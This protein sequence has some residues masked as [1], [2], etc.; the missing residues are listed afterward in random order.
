MIMKITLEITILTHLITILI[1]NNLMIDLI[2]QETQDLVT[3]MIL[4]LIK[5]ISI[6]MIET[7]LKVTISPEINMMITTADLMII[8]GITI[9]LLTEII[10]WIMREI[11]LIG[12]ILMNLESKAIFNHNNTLIIQ[13]IETI[14][15]TLIV[16]I[17]IIHLI[18]IR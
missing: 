12:T 2:N 6:I 3:I 18:S 7:N 8:K 4:T 16:K 13:I 15:I 1:K 11:T 9:D 17:L 14:N 10:I 5:R